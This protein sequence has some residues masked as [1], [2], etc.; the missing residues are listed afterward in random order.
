MPFLSAHALGSLIESAVSTQ[1][2]LLGR[3]VHAHITRTLEPPFPP[4]LSNHLINLYSKLDAPDSAQLL[5]SLT[6]TRYRSV[7]TWTALIAG[8]VQ[9][10]HFTSA[11]LH[12]SNMRRE[13][14]QPNDF[15]FPCLFKASAFL[16]SP[17][18]GQQLHALALK[19]S[20]IEDV[21]VGCSAFDMYCRTGLRE[22]ARKVFD[23]M[24]QRNI[25][26][27]NACISNSV[28]DGRSYDAA[29]KFVELL[30][31]GEE[32]PNSITFCVFLNACSDGLYLK[33]G[34]QLHGYVIRLGFRSDVSV[35]NGLIDFYGK[36]HEVKYSELVFDEINER[37]GVSWCTMLAVYEQNDIWEK[38]FMVFL[39]ARKEDIKPTE[40]MISSAL[41]A[42][43]GMAVLELGRSIHGLAVKSCKSNVFVGSAL[44][45]MYGKC[46]NIEDCESAFYEMPERNLITWNAVMGGYAH[47]GYADMALNL[48]EE[49]TSESHDV[50]PNYV[51]LVCV[52]TAC[53]RA[54]TVKIGM[55]IFESMRKKYGIQPGPEHYACVVDMLA[56]AGLV[57][58]AYEFIKKMPVPP[59]VSVWGALLGACRVYGKPE[60][61]KVAADNLFQLDPKD[62]GNHVILSNMFAA[63]GRW[64]EANLVRK[65]MKDVGIK[66]GAGFSWISVKNCVHIF[67]AKDTIHE[68]YPEIQAMLAKLKRDMKAAGYTADTNFA[69]YDLEEEEK[70]SE[71]WYHSEKIALA[72][73]LIAIPRGVPIRITKNLRV[74]VDCH[75]AIK[76]I[77]GIT[78]REIIV[79]D[80]NRFHCFKDYQCSCRDY[81]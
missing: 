40:F 48:F 12:F 29:L 68:R 61:G 42:C 14:V 30:R 6:P 76:F 73:G 46:G 31:V 13:C 32:P 74:C 21:F 70:E 79:R 36:C 10:G 67:Q 28:L 57:E 75:S 26:T 78:G 38:A 2:L 47:Q 59:T 41:S 50:V 15:T 45:D 43:A 34:R 80:N 20:L 66:K 3:A 55:D 64:E 24:P 19:T 16:H 37:N 49:M 58:R 4:F 7:V 71:V 18:T 17:V 62:S 27:W 53:S 1:S 44:V 54:G 22:Y 33:L 8:S 23:E 77:S 5:L 35:L 51:T 11:L 69:L 9:S 39:K 72:F 81:W 52:L 65:E 60:L 25:A 56:R 63:A